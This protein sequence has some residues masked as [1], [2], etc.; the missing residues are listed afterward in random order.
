M[1][2]TRLWVRASIALSCTMLSAGVGEK[3]ARAEATL[4]DKAAAQTLFDDGRKLMAAGKFGEACPKLAESQTLDP[5]VGTPVN[6]A[7]CYEPG[8][9]TASAWT[10]FL[11]AAH[12]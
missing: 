11:E 7:D 2:R 10:A 4:A 12:D 6:L 8:G 3:V 5:G 9:Q 1:H